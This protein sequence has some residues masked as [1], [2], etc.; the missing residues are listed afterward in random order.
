V[1][2]LG[3]AARAEGDLDR[4]FRFVAAEDPAAAGAVTA[5]ILDALQILERHPLIGRPVEADLRELVISRGKSG[6][7]ALYRY[8]EWE[9]VAMVLAL[10]HQREAGYPEAE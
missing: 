9:D 5:L 3:F 7:I 4:I 10:R 2:R 6:Y 8:F 1:A